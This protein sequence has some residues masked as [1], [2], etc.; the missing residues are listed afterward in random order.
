MKDFG[1]EVLESSRPETDALT[2]IDHCLRQLYADRTHKV[3]DEV[4]PA[5]TYEELIGAL[6]QAKDKIKSL[7]EERESLQE[8]IEVIETLNEEE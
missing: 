8:Y 7:K 6:L 1:K 2:C 3:E 5:L 4:S